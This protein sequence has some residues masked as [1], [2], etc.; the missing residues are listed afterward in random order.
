VPCPAGSQKR[1]IEMTSNQAEMPTGSDS[2]NTVPGADEPRPPLLVAL[3]EFTDRLHTEFWEI[4][5]YR[6]EVRNLVE[7]YLAVCA[8]VDYYRDLIRCAGLRGDEPAV[9]YP[10]IRI[11]AMCAHAYTGMVISG[12]SA[13]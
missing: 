6:A 2:S 1:D 8:E 9:L 7:S 13:K 11:A 5:T 12:K 10:L 3:D 4:K